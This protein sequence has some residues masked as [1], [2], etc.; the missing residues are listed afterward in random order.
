MVD[1][2]LVQKDFMEDSDYSA[3]KGIGKIMQDVKLPTYIQHYDVLGMIV[4]QIVGE[5]SDMTDVIRI[6]SDDD[7]E[8]NDFIREKEQRIQEYVKKSFT[9]NLNRLL[10]L[11]GINP[12]KEDFES[13]EEKQ[14]Y[15]KFLEEEKAKIVSPQE[16]EKQMSKSW[17]VRAVQWAEKKYEQDAIDFSMEDMEKER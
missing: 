1:G 2:R 8:K 14:E 15:L 10:A 12:N 7:Y 9:N 5:L 13:E 3:L 17:K 6:I 11:K 16:I 4:N